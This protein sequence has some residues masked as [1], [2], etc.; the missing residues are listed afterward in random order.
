[1]GDVAKL[2]PDQIEIVRDQI[3][4]GDPHQFTFSLASP[5]LPPTWEGQQEFKVHRPKRSE[6][7]VLAAYRASRLGAAGMMARDV[8]A[9]TDGRYIEIEAWLS[10]ML[11]E[12]PDCWWVLED[13]KR[14]A[15]ALGGGVTFDNVYNEDLDGVWEHIGPYLRSFKLEMAIP[16]RP[17]VAGEGEE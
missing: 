7:A 16:D 17:Y 13:G 14:V 1:M 2:T 4:P 8:I 3:S 5:A 10:V 6:S 11:D 12:A 15:P 9:N